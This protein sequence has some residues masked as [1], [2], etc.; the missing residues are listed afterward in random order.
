[1]RLDRSVSRRAEGE[2]LGDL[3]VYPDDGIEYDEYFDGNEHQQPE[4]PGLDNLNPP[5]HQYLFGDD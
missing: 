1:M 2:G 5:L 4:D 3:E